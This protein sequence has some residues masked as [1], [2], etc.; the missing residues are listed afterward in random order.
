VKNILVALWVSQL[1]AGCVATTH[2]LEAVKSGV[3]FDQQETRAFQAGL[4]RRMSAMERN[5]QRLDK[6][7]SAKPR[8]EE[9]GKRIA[10]IEA[11][12]QKFEKSNA[13]AVQM[14]LISSVHADSNDKGIAAVRTELDK[15]TA[16]IQALEARLLES[17]K[18]LEAGLTRLKDLSG[19]LK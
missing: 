10:D 18:Q 15:L 2:E 19:R 17:D 11:Q 9:V 1:V 5:L 8:H 13:L 3:S 4:E 6:A 7:G 14:G 12:L 16:E